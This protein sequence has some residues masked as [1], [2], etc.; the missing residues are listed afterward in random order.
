MKT[1][2]KIKQ[3][4]TEKGISQETLGEL[5][6][7]KKAA[8]NKYETGRVVNIKKSMLVKLADALGVLPADLL[9]DL[10]DESANR[11]SSPLTPAEH[12]LLSDFRQLNEDGREKVSEYTSDL[13][14]SG[15]YD[16]HAGEG[17]GSG[18]GEESA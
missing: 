13:V 1:S 7:V 5:V 14:A 8:I 6:G 12:S 4:R 18:S 15:R 11:P 16:L 9:D 2:E 17:A 3:L 10:P